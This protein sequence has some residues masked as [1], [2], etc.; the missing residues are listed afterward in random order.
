VRE[1]TPDE[2]MYWMRRYGWVRPDPSGVEFFSFF[3][4]TTD[5]ELA[6]YKAYADAMQP[7]ARPDFTFVVPRETKASVNQREDRRRRA[8]RTQAERHDTHW[9]LMQHRVPGYRVLKR[10]RLVRYYT[11]LPLDDDNI[12]SALKAIRDEIAAWFNVDDS[13][14]SGISWEPDQEKVGR[15]SLIN[16]HVR[17]ELT[18]APEGE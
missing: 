14:R 1:P 11:H 13:A 8:E 3:R 15:E 17:V 7:H 10:A 2:V 12:A 6:Q 5:I 9:L 18:L 4:G 16:G